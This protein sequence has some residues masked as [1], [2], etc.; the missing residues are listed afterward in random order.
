MGRRLL[1]LWGKDLKVVIRNHYLTVVVALAVLYVL[2]INFLI[3]AQLA[4]AADVV[5]W[6]Q[7]ESQA[8]LQLYQVAG[9]SAGQALAV[10]S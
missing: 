8:M 2:A 5:I 4:A 3:P 9:S 1:S 7:T 10:N 6:D